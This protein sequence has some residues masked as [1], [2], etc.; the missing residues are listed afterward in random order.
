MLFLAFSRPSR[1]EAGNANKSV[2]LFAVQHSGN[3][4]FVIAI[5]FAGCVF[6][7]GLHNFIFCVREPARGRWIVINHD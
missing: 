3:L 5:D 6:Q 7:S 2:D 1:I 4:D